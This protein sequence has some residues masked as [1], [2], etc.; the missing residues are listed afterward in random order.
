MKKAFLRTYIVVFILFMAH[1]NIF[2]APSIQLHIQNQYRQN[3]KGIIATLSSGKITI[4]G[5]E[6]GTLQ[7]PLILLPD[8]IHIQ[9][10]YYHNTTLYINPSNYKIENTIRKIFT[11]KDLLNPMFYIV[12][13]GLWII[14]FVIFAETG[15]FAGFFLPGDTLLFI[16][17]IYIK[18]LLSEFSLVHLPV[19]QQ[20]LFI[21]SVVA[22]AAIIG[23]IVGYYI[24]KLM[25]HQMYKWKDNLLFKHRYLIEAN[26]FYNQHG[27]WTLVLSRFLPI[28]R[29]FAP[30][31][32]GII[33]MDIKKFMLFTII[34]AIAWVGSMIFAG[35]FLENIILKKLHFDLREHLDLVVILIIAISLLPI[36]IKFIFPRLKKKKG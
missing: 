13:G 33:S 36:I 12:N 5:D 25:G 31:I 14:L 10:S 30:I 21:C 18:E 22:I 35:H 28:I 8:S 1:T 24:G 3:V 27:V 26:H 7:V 19:I 4:Y 16:S 32:A 34:G 29:T 11:W 23:N 15:L 9:A 20:L 2:S 6:D 17:G